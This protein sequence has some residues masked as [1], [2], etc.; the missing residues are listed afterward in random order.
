MCE[1]VVRFIPE[2]Q[3]EPCL[4]KRKSAAEGTLSPHWPGWDRA[5]GYRE[6]AS[7]ST[8]GVT[9]ERW[10]LRKGSICT[11]IF[12]GEKWCKG[13]YLLRANTKPGQE[14]RHCAMRPQ[15]IPVPAECKETKQKM[16][17]TAGSV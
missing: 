17:K 2:E 13:W 3:A 8:S 14:P 1:R 12:P 7:R 9:S 11:G 16:K 5:V 10:S 15:H 6:G 4:G